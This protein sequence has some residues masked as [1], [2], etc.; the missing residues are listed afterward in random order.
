MQLL[1]GGAGGAAVGGGIVWNLMRGGYERLMDPNRP[2]PRWR[3]IVDWVLRIM[4]QIRH[5]QGNGRVGG[6]PAGGLGRVGLG[7]NQANGRAGGAP[8]DQN[9]KLN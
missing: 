7:A 9:G 4:D 2:T 5:L 3:R 1:G 6:N 8:L